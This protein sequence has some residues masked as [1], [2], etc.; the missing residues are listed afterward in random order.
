MTANIYSL[1]TRV[2][3]SICKA[4]TAIHVT[5]RE[6]H[7]SYPLLRRGNSLLHPLRSYPLLWV[8]LSSPHFNTCLYSL[9]SSIAL[10]LNIISLSLSCHSIHIS[11]SLCLSPFVT[12]QLWASLFT[13]VCTVLSQS[14]VAFDI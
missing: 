12:S 8:L 9:C 3:P 10:S 11:L 14:T 4:A 5:G 7:G 6:R 13:A 2:V 1:K